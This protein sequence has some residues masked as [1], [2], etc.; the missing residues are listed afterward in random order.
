MGWVSPPSDLTLSQDELHIWRASLAPPPAD[1]GALY[2]VLDREERLRA[3]RYVFA[4]HRERFIVARG[5]LRNILSLYLSLSPSEILFEQNA[6]G[7]PSLKTGA[8][9]GTHL[10]FNVSHSEDLALYAFAADAEVGVDVES[11]RPD[12]ATERIAERFFSPAEVRALK[13][14]PAHLKAQAF[15]NCWTRKEAYIKALGKGLSHPLE[16]FTVSLTPG[17]P[18]ELLCDETDLSEAGRWELRALQVDLGYAAALAVPKRN[19]Q[20]RCYE[21]RAA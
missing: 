14:L 16:S 13:E 12:F 21:W 7:K 5:V 8:T 15:F 10:H 17:L 9:A 6:Y 20:L 18:A 3:E 1:L 19:W 2:E 11:I 4:R